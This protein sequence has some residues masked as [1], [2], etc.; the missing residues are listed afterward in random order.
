[1]MPKKFGDKNGQRPPHLGMHL[2][3]Q[4]MLWWLSV[5]GCR[6]P[7]IYQSLSGFVFFW[8]ICPGCFEIQGL[9]F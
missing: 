5:V 9:Q 6:C 4:K 2:L 7:L 3:L 8:P 1:M